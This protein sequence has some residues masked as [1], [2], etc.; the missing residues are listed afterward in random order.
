MPDEP[1]PQLLR[2][3]AESRVAL[4]HAQ[5]ME[6][7]IGQ[8]HR[9]GGPRRGLAATRSIV[10]SILSGFATG[11]AAPLRLRH[12]GLLALVAAALT[13]WAAVAGAA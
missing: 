8:L 9:A 4:D 7:V 10:A 11:L 5:F 12:A 6:R 13:L 1:D 2:W 3:F